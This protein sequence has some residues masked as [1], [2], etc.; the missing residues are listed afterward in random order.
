MTMTEILV[1]GG[2]GLP[3]VGISFYFIVAARRMMREEAERASI[4]QASAQARCHDV[5]R[6]KARCIAANARTGA[7]R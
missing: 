5:K 4:R 3:I 2:F 1:L 6:R 7:C